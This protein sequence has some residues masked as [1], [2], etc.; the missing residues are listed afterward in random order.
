MIR[1]ENHLNVFTARA[2][3]E[4]TVTR[5]RRIFYTVDGNIDQRE[6]PVEI[7][8]GNTPYIFE[9]GHDGYVLSIR[10]E[11]WRDSFSGDRS[12]VNRRYVETHG[13]W[14]AVDIREGDP[15]YFLVGQT[16]DRVLPIVANDTIVGVGIV[17]GAKMLLIRSEFDETVVQVSDS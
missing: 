12:E 5:V 11:E 16:I 13:K 7:V 4:E 9:S 3:G 14:I 6:G 10:P 2:V 15:E 17:V 8:I 1:G